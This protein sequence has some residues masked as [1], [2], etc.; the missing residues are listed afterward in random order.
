MSSAELDSPPLTIATR[1]LD[2]SGRPDL[3]EL[4]ALSPPFVAS[5]GGKLKG[6]LR[7]WEILFKDLPGSLLH[8]LA[9]RLLA[10]YFATEGEQDRALEKQLAA[11]ER[12][13][14]DG[15]WLHIAQAAAAALPRD[16]PFADATVFHKVE[17]TLQ[18]RAVLRQHHIDTGW[19]GLLST[20]VTLRNR[21]HGHPGVIPAAERAACIP[22][23]VDFL[24]TVLC[25]LQ[26]VL[27]GPWRATFASSGTPAVTARASGSGPSL[28]LF[29]F[30][31]TEDEDTNPRPSL[32]M[33]ETWEG[34][35]PAYITEDGALRRRQDL[36]PA[37]ILARARRRQV[38]TPQS[39]AF[40]AAAAN[41]A[42]PTLRDCLSRDDAMCEWEAS[43]DGALAGAGSLCIVRSEHPHTVT[44]L[45]ARASLRRKN[46]GDLVI[47]LGA[48]SLPAAASNANGLQESIFS[49]LDP[50][51]AP[52]SRL[53]AAIQDLADTG[54]HH[55][56]IV[57][58]DHA[59]AYH[60]AG[61][62]PLTLIASAATL[63]E[64]HRGA[65]WLRV[66]M[67]IS[68][69]VGDERKLEELVDASEARLLT[70]NVDTGCPVH[71]APSNAPQ[72]AAR[73]SALGASLSRWLHR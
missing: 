22:V 46:S 50:L 11:L 23:M 58:I 49:S 41:A 44:E 57:L 40:A 21:L 3:D 9:L 35:C 63:C 37:L 43:L 26:P 62:S 60:G 47:Y 34:G 12:P 19:Q 32:Q 10:G 14:V 67:G 39:S 7:D 51:L 2:T 15:S 53:I 69:P 16:L 18:A 20:L 31:F 66:T 54:S 38:F 17:G 52:V 72:L 27:R 36:A 61:R 1:G 64:R 29:P 30:L 4:L 13:M 65:D 70:F 42:V 48:E 68:D 73:V 55:R 33:L 45:L 28:N 71:H 56:C 59:T 6:D 25:E 8:Y 24:T 5:L